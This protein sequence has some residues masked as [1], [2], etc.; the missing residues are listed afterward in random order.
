MLGDLFGKNAPFNS[1]KLVKMTTSLTFDDR[2]ARV[3][4]GW[5]PMPILSGSIFKKQ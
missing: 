1:R 2:K 4:F 5:D 3:T